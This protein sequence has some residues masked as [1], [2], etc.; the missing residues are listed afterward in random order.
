M[1]SYC[2]KYAGGREIQP[3]GNNASGIYIPTTI[4]D[5]EMLINDDNIA[6]EATNAT[7]GE[8]ATMSARFLCT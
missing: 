2:D 7:N 6:G 1:L 4:R 8:Y 5:A 3:P